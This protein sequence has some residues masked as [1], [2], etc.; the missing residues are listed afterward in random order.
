MWIYL[1]KRVSVTTFEFI[2]QKKKTKERMKKNSQI[3]I[4]I[5]IRCSFY[6]R[7]SW[8]LP[9]VKIRHNVVGFTLEYYKEEMIKRNY[10]MSMQQPNVCIHS[11]RKKQKNHWKISIRNLYLDTFHTFF[12]P[13][14][15]PTSAHIAHT[16]TQNFNLI[17]NCST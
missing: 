3:I 17:V 7:M 16:Y 12:N 14:L 4:C 2:S 15:F 13:I 9:F 5:R 1:Y 11:S 10:T 8:S 6:R